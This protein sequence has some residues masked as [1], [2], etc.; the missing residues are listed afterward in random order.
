MERE[1]LICLE[2]YIAWLLCLWIV[3][4]TFLTLGK[5]LSTCVRK[6]VSENN[7]AWVESN[8]LMSL[9]RISWCNQI[10]YLPNSQNFPLQA[11]ESEMFNNFLQE[12]KGKIINQRGHDFWLLIRK[13]KLSYSVSVVG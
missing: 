11:G 9:K 6:N 4:H 1:P 2:R 7:L 12:L 13:G 5:C 10:C 3:T 8:Y